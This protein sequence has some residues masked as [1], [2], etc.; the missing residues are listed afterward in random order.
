MLVL[1][2]DPGLG[3]TGYGLLRTAGPRVEVVEAGALR[4]KPATPLPGRL[5]ELHD[6][7]AEVLA[8]FRPDAVAVEQL[9]SSYAHPRTA[10][11]MGHAR[12]VIFLA[13]A[14]A[15][16]PVAGYPPARVKKSLTGD[17]RAGKEQMQVA[18][19]AAL[20]LPAPPEPHDVADA[21]AVALCH[22]RTV[23][24]SVP[25]MADALRKAAPV[26]TAAEL[27]RRAAE[28]GGR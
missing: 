22:I 10:I 15:G 26:P 1:G 2:I 25:G 9:F 18:I 7:L 13:A 3:C 23:E 16:I 4:T 21:L 5:R 28:A 14:Q 11:L 24:G 17:G 12:G 19:Q 20:R 27:R 6:G 8:E